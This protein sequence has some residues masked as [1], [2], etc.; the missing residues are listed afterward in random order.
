[1]TKLDIC[2]KEDYGR[3]EQSIADLRNEI[4][5]LKELKS[6][7]EFITRKEAAEILKVSVTTVINYEKRGIIIAY[8]IG[9]RIRYKREDILNAPVAIERARSY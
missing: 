2:T 1:M 4:N 7:K 9:N 3:L 8:R 5:Q 6:P